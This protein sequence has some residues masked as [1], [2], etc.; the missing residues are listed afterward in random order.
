MRG[1]GFAVV[2]GTTAGAPL[3][4]L[5]FEG[6][7][8]LPGFCPV[9]GRGQNRDR[10]AHLL[11]DWLAN[12]GERH[13][14]IAREFR[15]VESG[16]RDLARNIETAPVELIKRAQSHQVVGAHNGVD[17]GSPKAAFAEQ[18]RDSTRAGL[19]REVAGHH[20]ARIER[21]LALG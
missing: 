2:H 10:V 11:V 9:H 1:H 13:P 18:S 15:V 12:R 21:Q 8:L 16:E 17:F 5:G 3:D 20:V 4:E 14:R 7:R 19:A 6:E